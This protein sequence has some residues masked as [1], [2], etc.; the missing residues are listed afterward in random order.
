MRE[1]FSSVQRG[2]TGASFDEAFQSLIVLLSDRDLESVAEEFMQLACGD[3]VE[4][5]NEAV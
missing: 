4:A 2:L 1:R 5:R 3:D